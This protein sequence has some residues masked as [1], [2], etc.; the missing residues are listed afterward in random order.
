M[1][2][3]KIEIKQPE[4]VLIFEGAYFHGVLINTQYSGSEQLCGK[5]Y[6]VIQ[7]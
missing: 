5:G 2:I 6:V 3:F 4:L 7:P 1:P